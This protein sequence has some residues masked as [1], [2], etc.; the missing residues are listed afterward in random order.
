VPARERT[1][2]GRTSLFLRAPRRG[3]SAADGFAT[4]LGLGSTDCPADSAVERAVADSVGAA[5]PDALTTAG[6]PECEAERSE[7]G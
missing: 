1:N 6:T 3:T 5:T 7:A 2:L 4:A